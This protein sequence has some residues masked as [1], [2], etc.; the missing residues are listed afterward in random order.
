LSI[1]IINSL[2]TGALKDFFDADLAI[3]HNLGLFI[4]VGLVSLLSGVLAGIFPAFYTTYFNPAMA[5]SGSFFHTM[6]NKWLRN[7]TTGIQFIAAVF[8]ITTS[9]FIK[10]Q[11]D[12]LRNK[13]WGIQTENVLYFNSEM[14]RKKVDDI[15]AELKQ[16]PVIVDVTAAAHYPGQE[17]TQGWGRPFDDVQINLNIW[18]VKTD[19]FDFFGV[20]VAEGERFKEND[21]DKMILNRSFS[22]K[23][24][25]ND[26]L[27]GK[28]LSDH[29]II[30][31]AED[32]NY[33]SVHGNIQPLA[34]IPIHEGS[35]GWY[36]NWVFVKTNNANTKQA[37]RHIYDTW[38]KFSEEPVE[39]LQL[40]DTIQ[41]LYKKEYNTFSLVSICGIIAIIVAIIGLYGLILFDA[42]SKRKSIAIRKIHGASFIE[43]MLMLNKSLFIRFAVAYF[44]SVPLVYFSVFRWLEVFAYKTPIYWWI[45]AL[46]GLIVLIIFLLT[47]SWESYKVA[48]ENP[49]EVVKN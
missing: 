8:L 34:F 37:I 3:P 25:F 4:I 30:G 17:K 33:K 18:P 38:K 23:Y 1:L 16:N 19:F 45:F 48:R 39:I 24:G 31:I 42:K 40:T 32:F 43:T 13:D 2:N 5:L 12:Y 11:Y 29:E 47:V 46:G 10:I 7:L 14:E 20:K 15:M 44:I 41:A 27:V 22:E 49:A 9:L 26:N 28:E 35:K 36:Y 6:Q 21:K